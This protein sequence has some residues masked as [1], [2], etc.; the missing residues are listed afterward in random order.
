MKS[1]KSARIY[2]QV[3]QGGDYLHSI[4]IDKHYDDTHN[5]RQISMTLSFEKQ[6][7]AET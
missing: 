3:T 1:F 7:P 5:A 2:Q 6:Y 4:S